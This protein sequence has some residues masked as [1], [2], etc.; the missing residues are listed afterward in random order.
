MRGAHAI[1]QHTKTGE[2]ETAN[3]ATTIN[4]HRADLNRH[5]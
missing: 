4:D 3:T 2:E 1:V 5:Y